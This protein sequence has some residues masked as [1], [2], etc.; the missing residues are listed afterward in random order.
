MFSDM[1]VGISEENRTVQQPTLYLESTNFIT[2]TAAFADQMKAMVPNLSVK[3]LDC[4]HWIMLEKAD[5]TN[6]F[7]EQFFEEGQA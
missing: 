2:A 3:K 4:S 7:L 5:E 1:R 6:A